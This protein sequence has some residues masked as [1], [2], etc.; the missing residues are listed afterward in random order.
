MSNNVGRVQRYLKGFRAHDDLEAG[1]FEKADGT[2]WVR[3]PD[4]S[5][6][7]VGVGGGSQAV[8]LLTVPISAAEVNAAQSQATGI[9]IVPATIGKVIVPLQLIVSQDADDSIGDASLAIGYG[10]AGTAV[11]LDANWFSTP[12]YAAFVTPPQPGGIAVASDTGLDFR[13]WFSAMVAADSG[14]YSVSLVYSALTPA[15]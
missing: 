2:V 15:A 14:P 9:V 3:N 8:S 6:T 5:E 10:A 4:G 12:P 1:L 13:V 11:N 7:Q